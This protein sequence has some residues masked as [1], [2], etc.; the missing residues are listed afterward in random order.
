MKLPFPINRLARLGIP[1]TALMLMAGC[2]TLDDL[3]AAMAHYDQ[4]PWAERAE[5][6]GAEGAGCS[7]AR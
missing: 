3:G 6:W 4:L 5:M 2:G 1:L 7:G